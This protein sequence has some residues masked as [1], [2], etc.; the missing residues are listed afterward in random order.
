MG[1]D[2]VTKNELEREI[3]ATV[4]RIKN[5]IITG[6]LASLTVAM[7]AAFPV[8][9]YFGQVD[10]KVMQLEETNNERGISK[11]G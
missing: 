7:A 3:E 11:R 4:L 1:E 6:V 10:Q 8:I 5:W 2:F 9:Y